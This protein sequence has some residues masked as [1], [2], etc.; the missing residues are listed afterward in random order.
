MTFKS[1]MAAYLKLK[2]GQFSSL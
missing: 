2:V 1:I